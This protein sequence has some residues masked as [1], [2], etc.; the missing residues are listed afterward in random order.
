MCFIHG[1]VDVYSSMGAAAVYHKLRTMGI[2]A[3]LHFYAKIPHAFK[4]FPDQNNIATW[5]DR[6][7]EWMKRL[8]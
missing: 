5:V 7:W 2:P 3:E 1:D 4:S 6:A 8:E